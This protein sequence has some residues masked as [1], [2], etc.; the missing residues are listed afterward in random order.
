MGRDALQHLKE[1][2]E[3][4]PELQAEYERLKPRFDIVD[5]LIR[6]R[7]KVGLTQKQLGALV[8]VSQG[9]IARLES[10]EHSPRLETV[11]DVARALGYRVDVKLVKDQRLARVRDASDEHADQKAAHAPK[12]AALTRR[13]S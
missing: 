4:N 11:V 1:L 12:Q 8:G 3:Q 2:R 9:V 13:A 5:Q 6:A 7:K 10:A